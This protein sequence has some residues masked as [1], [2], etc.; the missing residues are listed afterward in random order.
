MR[1]RRGYDSGER[2]RSTDGFVPWEFCL[3]THISPF[4]NLPEWCSRRK[5]HT[6]HLVCSLFVAT[7][8]ARSQTKTKCWTAQRTVDGQPDLQSVWNFATQTPLERPQEFAGKEVLSDEELFKFRKQHDEAR[9]EFLANESNNAVGSY[10]TFWFDAG[11][12]SARTSLIVDPADGLLPALTTQGETR[13]ADARAA[14]ERSAGPEDRSVTDRCIMGFNAGPP[15]I[16][17]I[18]NNYVQL[19]QTHSAVVIYTEMIHNARIIPLDG[20][21]HGILRQ[22]DGDSRGHWEGDTLIVDTINFSDK[23]TG[24]LNLSP[25]LDENAHL[26]ERFRRVS[27]STLVYEFTVDDPAVWT[28]PWTARVEMVKS[29]EGIYEYACHEGNYGLA[30]ILSAARAVE[31]AG[32]AERTR[33]K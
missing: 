27:A 23:G 4:V 33:Q 29:N 6:I 8:P 1:N 7:S 31:A 25:T 3:S 2:G 24:T 20:R 17:N 10:N 15:I 22:W 32:G 5:T 19:F 9:L 12:S 26:I 16:P 28:R 21:P 14:M 18:Y 11:R 30:N 13:R